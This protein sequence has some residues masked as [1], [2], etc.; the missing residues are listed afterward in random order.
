M[1]ATARIELSLTRP[2]AVMLRR[3]LASVS[4]DAS[5]EKFDFAKKLF[6]LLTMTTALEEWEMSE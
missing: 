5:D 3:V 1:I 6:T 4:G 2:E